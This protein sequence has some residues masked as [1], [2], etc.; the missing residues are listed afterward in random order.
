MYSARHAVQQAPRAS[1]PALVRGMP[2][3]EDFGP[4]PVTELEKHGINAA[5]VKKLQAAG[6]HTVES[7][8]SYE[9][10]AAYC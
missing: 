9:S 5:D 7:V 2:L 4:L 6:L 10:L 1:T 3:Q 8:R